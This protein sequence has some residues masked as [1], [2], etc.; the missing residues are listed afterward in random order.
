[1][2]VILL[3]IDGPMIPV[4]AYYLPNQTKPAS[5]FDPIATALLLRLLD[6]ASAKLV[7]S[8]TWGQFGRKRNEQLLSLNGIDPSYLHD[9]WI[10]PRRNNSARHHEI[11][12]W[13]DKHPE[14]VDYVAFD[15]ER[16]DS[17]IVPKFVQCCTT[18][19]MSMRNFSEARYYL[20][21]TNHSCGTN[22]AGNREMHRSTIE[23]LKRRE[24]MNT[25]RVGEQ[26][27]DLTMKMCD[28]LFPYITPTQR[29][30]EI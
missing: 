9:D 24:V 20:G 29:K 7:I 6:D 12:W 10:T 25:T 1:M 15:D 17:T 23:Q 30:D 14:V 8:S 13:L 28:D 21:L 2:K 3:D 16:L 18:N 11:K 22:D 5:V 19:G 4:K 27:Y 26:W